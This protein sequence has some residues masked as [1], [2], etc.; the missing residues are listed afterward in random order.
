MKKNN[1][2]FENH[3]DALDSA[4]LIDRKRGEFFELKYL[5][6]NYFQAIGTN[7]SK[8]GILSLRKIALGLSVKRYRILSVKN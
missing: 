5:A 6:S 7:N 8:E 4:I 2:N 3:I 1:P